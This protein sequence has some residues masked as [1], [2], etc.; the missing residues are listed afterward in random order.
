MLPLLALAGAISLAQQ[1]SPPNR[2]DVLPDVFQTQSSAD[3]LTTAAPGPKLSSPSGSGATIPKTGMLP[4]ALRRQADRRFLAHRG[5]SWQALAGPAAPSLADRLRLARAQQARLLRQ[6]APVANIARPPAHALT[7][8]IAATPGT[9]QS[10]GPVQVDTAAYGPVTGRITSLVADPNSSGNT[11]Y[12]GATGGGVWKSTNAAGANPSFVPLTDALPVFS[13][14]LASLSIGALSIQPTSSSV[15]LAGTGDINDAL[16]SYY[17]VGILRS[18]DGGNTWSLIQGSSD[19][20]VG[21]L[22]NYSFTGNG[23]A[24]FA[25]STASPNLVVAAV[26][27]SIEGVLVNAGSDQNMRAGLYY[28]SDAGQTWYFGIIEDDSTHVV[29]SP[30]KTNS[31]PG[32]SVTSVVWNHVRQRF[33]AAVRFHGYYE[34]LDG[35]TWTRLANQPG[36]S[37]S[38]TACPTNTGVLGQTSCPIFRGVLAVQPVTGDMFALTTDINDLDQGLFQDVCSTSGL[39]VTNCASS[40]VAFGTQIASGALENGTSDPTVPSTTIPLSDYDL[41]LSAVASQ[42]DTILFA[43]T[44]DIYRCSL[45]NSCAWRNTTNIQT[46]AA[47]QVAPSQHATESTFGSTGLLYFANDGGLWR[48]TDTVAQT[49]SV[50]AATDA[51]HFQNLNSG[52]GSLAEITHFS[53]SPSSASILLAGMGGFGTVSTLS[54]QGGWQQLLTGEGSYTAIDPSNLQNWYAEAGSGVD[55]LRCT[56]GTHCNA[57]GF[58]TEPVIGSAQD[59]GDADYFYDAAPWILDPLNTDNL[60]LGTCRVWRGPA[61]GGSGWSASNLLSPMLDGNQQPFC[62]G[63]AELRSIG[64]GLDASAPSGSE[65]IYAGISGPYD[66][67]GTTPGHIFT[68]TVPASGSETTWADL[69][70]SPV[71]NSSNNPQFNPGGFAISSIAVD[72]HDATGQTLY[73]TMQGFSGNG[74][75]EGEVYGSTDGG[76]HWLNLTSSLPLAPANS[77]VV[78]PNVPS[79]LYVALDTGVY[80][81]TNVANCSAIGGDCWTVYGSGLPNAP[82]T[83]LQV[84]SAGASSILQA[85]TYGRGIWQLELLTA[86]AQ[87]TLTPP[88]YTFASR[89]NLTSSAAVPFTLTNTGS[90]AMAIA[91]IQVIGD[92]TETN[93]CGLSLATASTCTIQVV[94]TPSVT[95]DR[96]GTLTVYANIGGGHLASTLDGTG[97]APGT[98]TP[99]PSSLSFPA[100]VQG[101]GSAAQNVT[102]QNIGG[103][104]VQLQPITITADYQ[105]S[106]NSCGSSLAPAAICVVSIVFSPGGLGDR[107]GHLA[108]PSNLAASPTL[109]PLDGTG[110]TAPA[111]TLN[112]ASLAFPST[113]R[114]AVSAS[115]GIIVTNSGGAPALL[116]LPTLLGD[117][118]ITA[119]SCGSTLAPN[120]S[121][122][123]QIA[124]APTNLGPR[125]GLLT[126][127]ADVAG[128]QVTASLS[129]TGVAPAALT[130]LPTALTF[131]PATVGVTSA[132]QSIRLTS[133]GG[134]PVQLQ[135]PVITGDYAI[136]AN[137]CGASLGP[138][139]NC[140]LQIT[141]TPSISGD[142]P[143]LLTLAA[144][145]AG[146]SVVAPLDGTGIS[147]PLLS[148]NPLSLTFADTSVGSS[149]AGQTISVTN[150]GGTAAQLLNPSITG[151]FSL[152]SNGCGSTIAPG[153]ACTLQIIFTPTTIGTRT[154]TLTLAGINFSAVSPALRPARSRSSVLQPATA[155]SQLTVALSGNGVAPPVLTFTPS[156]VS[157][158]SVSSGAASSPQA[159]T[160]TNT[161]TIAASLQPPTVTANFQI[162]GTTCTTALAAQANCA[163]DVIFHPSATGVLQGSL[164]LSGSMAHGQIVDPLSGTGLAPMA[165]TLT[166]G[167]LFYSATVVNSPSTRQSVAVTNT[168]GTTLNL[169][170][171]V[172]TGDYQISSNSCG[173]TLAPGPT[174][175]VIQIVFKPTMPGDRPGQLQQSDG[176]SGD[177]QQVVTLDGTGLAPGAVTLTPSSLSFGSVAVGA[178]SPATVT[179]TNTGGAPVQ[180][181]SPVLTGDYSPGSNGCSASLL[182]NNS[183]TLQIVF[184]PS[185]AGTR[186]GTLTL[187]S[188]AANTPSSTQL[189]GVGVAPG[190]VALAPN[191][192]NFPS[193]LVGA[194]SSSEVLTAANTGGLAVQLG[195]PS[196]SGDYQVMPAGTTCTGSLAASSSCLL[197]VAFAPTTPGTRT[198]ALSLPGQFTG[199]PATANL[200][201]SATAPG[202]L[203]LA[204]ASLSFGSIITGTSSAAK[205]IAVTN[206]GGVAIPVGTATVAGDYQIQANSCPASLAPQASCTL[207][208]VFSPTTGS[209]RPG[210][211]TLSGSGAGSQVTAMLDGTGVLPGALSLSTSLLNYGSLVLGTTSAPQPLMM[212]NSGGSYLTLQAPVLSSAEYQ[213]SASTC[214]STLNVGASCTLSITFHPSAVVD[215]QAT[216]TVSASG[217]AVQAHATLDGSGLAAA[218]LAFTPVSLGFASVQVGKASAQQTATLTN[219]GGVPAALLVPVLAGDYSIAASTC[220]TTLAPSASCTLQITF[221]PASA[222]ARPG[223]VTITAADGTTSAVLA[224]SGTGTSPPALVLTPTS[225]VFNATI[226]GTTTAAQNVTIAN[227]SSA[228]LNLLPFTLTGDYNLSADSCTG[229]PLNPTYSCTLSITFQPTAGGPRTGLLT[230]SDGV[231]THTVSLTGTGLSPATDTLSASSLSFAPQVFG[232]VS[233]AQTVSLTNSGGATLGSILTS[234]VGPFTATQCGSG[235]ILGGGLTCPIAVQYAPTGIGAQTGILTISDA[236][237][238]QTVALS[239]QGLLPP[240]GSTKGILLPLSLDFGPFAVSAASPM[241]PVTLTNDGVT[242]LEGITSAVGT[243]NFVIATNTCG[244]SL[245][246]GASCT[247]GI[248]F[249]PQQVGSAIDQLTVTSTSLN[250]PLTVALSGSGEDFQLSVSGSSSDLV[251]DGQTAT[252]H[253]VA[254]PVGSSA[255]ILSLTCAGAPANSSCLANPVTLAVAGSATGSITINIA[256]GLTAGLAGANRQYPLDR[257]WPWKSGAALALLLPGLI[258]RGNWRRNCLILVGSLGL[259]FAP[260]ACGVHA[261]GGSSSSSTSTSSGST[262]PGKYAITVTASFPGAQRTVNLT[263]TVE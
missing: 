119:N 32:N 254:T 11:L 13:N 4:G 2:N 35:I 18:A 162:S 210:L 177:P 12:V 202:T 34:S 39:A 145:I 93:N 260:I 122:A 124:F 187:T 173:P 156:P 121:C 126:L 64:A 148:L 41:T 154:G 252:Y 259:V 38:T 104:A 110:V 214:G 10:L 92:Y 196:V 168:G 256:T 106:S 118:Q 146:G 29:Q 241:Q 203:A 213:I 63:N 107:P 24:G 28:S 44:E 231:E 159:I 37:L 117:Y 46:C 226:L 99:T 229:A 169:P 33:Y 101:T 263:L 111:L 182:P 123:L 90:A 23:F 158:P 218:K 102:I 138:G 144:N 103:V 251:T 142:R 198:G 97:L 19:L 109:V 143:G 244:A 17:G 250:G 192:L 207:Q 66:G 194:I 96:P 223:S 211:L 175:C 221:S 262:P 27:Q 141:F 77:I 59:E 108:I 130:L 171:A 61:T 170:P 57:A 68:S 51:S 113:A 240:Q 89:Q 85:A 21:G 7:P 112:P 222:G 246:A 179:A 212:T 164:V 197:Q 149:S 238:S 79:I 16:D 134:I 174:P 14:T 200:S 127:A 120:A 176:V 53:V 219:T 204:P 216:I 71:T 234:V 220:G 232:T 255:G 161:G 208:I 1:P 157:F 165:L 72:P 172:I 136:S 91:S 3:K 150:S 163:I 94:F 8:D 227:L 153:A 224:L 239:G 257:H 237:H 189:T 167:S 83:S 228:S 199:S 114:G 125:A 186:S 105:I 9:W 215:Q 25:W 155:A 74:I 258:L 73:A 67:G 100:T 201:G 129:G 245:P 50:C 151:D 80:Y 20:F 84:F 249:D 54:G 133:V 230:V 43:G 82:V 178:S 78:D 139:A 98:V 69:Y 45:A 160:V 225:L 128:G 248:A 181:Q 42:Q 76:A 40:T 233:A 135:T 166:P 185:A 47:A 70:N 86:P 55:I 65:Q 49:G 81:T 184:R 191:P 261:S 137:T 36:S 58:G 193:T 205:P 26:A 56:A 132:A 87:G 242:P 206:S 5:I 95:G 30:N 195:A 75:S 243:G 116:Q 15:I 60:L 62:D 48:S 235:S 188:D 247:L 52:I 183:C 88:S 190:N 152:S 209:D 131:L 115:A 180:F 22:Q 140:T 31:P 147:L 253:L 6:E 217:G 236:L